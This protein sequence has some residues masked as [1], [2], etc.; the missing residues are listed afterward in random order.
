MKV[1]VIYGSPETSPGGKGMDFAASIVGKVKKTGLVE[2]NQG[3]AIGHQMEVTFVKNKT[4]IPMRGSSFDL[5]FK[6]RGRRAQGSSSY[7]KEVLNVAK[8]WKLVQV[9]GSWF[10][11]AK[12]V[13]IQGLDAA[14]RWLET[15]AGAATLAMLRDQVWK[16]EVSWLDGTAEE[17]L[18]ASDTDEEDDE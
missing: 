10:T 5:L 7:A 8:Y 14:G 12:G 16:R 3:L 18:N 15:E 9:S 13:R 17:E 6:K 4:A 2:S 11:L 1:G